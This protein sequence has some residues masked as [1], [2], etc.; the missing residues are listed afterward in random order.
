[1]QNLPKTHEASNALSK[2]LVKIRAAL[3]GDRLRALEDI[4]SN[5]DELPRLSSACTGTGR[6]SLE[7]I[8]ALEGHVTIIEGL[9]DAE[10][11]VDTRR[12]EPIWALSARFSTRVEK[13]EAATLNA[14]FTDEE[15]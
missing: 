6:W 12:A 2:N 10:L 1:M 11:D 13:L 3:T 15:D 14:G 9:I 8:K 7:S 5:D 4:F